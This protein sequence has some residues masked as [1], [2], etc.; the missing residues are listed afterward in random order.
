[1]TT[2]TLSHACTSYCLEGMW[3]VLCTWKVA[4][5]GFSFKFCLETGEMLYSVEN[6]DESEK[7]LNTS[8]PNCHWPHPHASMFV[9][10]KYV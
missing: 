8:N 3:L 4:K 1:M 9:R 10:L 6:T 5:T 2:F 7:V